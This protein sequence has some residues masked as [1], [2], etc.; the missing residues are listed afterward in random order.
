MSGFQDFVETKTM[1]SNQSPSTQ[2]PDPSQFFAWMGDSDAVDVQAQPVPQQP[3][4]P[5]PSAPQPSAPQPPQHPGGVYG[6]AMERPIEIAPPWTPS[7][8]DSGRNGETPKY[9]HNPLAEYVKARQM[10]AT[11]AWVDRAVKAKGEAVEQAWDLAESAAETLPDLLKSVAIGALALGSGF[12]AAPLIDE[13]GVS[14]FV[15]AVVQW[16]GVT[17]NA[18]KGASLGQQD[19]RI[20]Y[21]A[22][23][24]FFLASFILFG[25]LT[26]L[27]QPKTAKGQAFKAK[28]LMYG[29]L[30]LA[31]I[32]G[33]WII[34]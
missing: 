21:A 34:R 28:F 7:V 4:A 14:R 23:W 26:L 16:D 9:N 33:A 15:P 12:L 5:Q 6:A 13:F 19:Y 1:Q 24:R 11:A 20:Q 2:S 17:V 3:S 18:T 22:R 32:N 25:G 8:T 31:P 29:H 10:A 27:W 30:F